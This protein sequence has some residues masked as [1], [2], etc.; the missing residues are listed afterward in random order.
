[1]VNKGGIHREITNFL[2]Y[3]S[4]LIKS[5]GELMI[6]KENFKSIPRNQESSNLD[7]ISRRN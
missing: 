5:D 6:M 7:L 2:M 4:K 1:M 3:S